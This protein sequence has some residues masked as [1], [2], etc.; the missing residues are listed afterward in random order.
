MASYKKFSKT[1]EFMTPFSAWETIT[2]FI[3]KDKLIWEPFYGDGT[4]AQH[5]RDLGC[6]VYSEQED[7]FSSVHGDIVVS[8]PPFSKK[9]QVFERLLELNN[10]FILLCPA[11]VLHTQWLKRMFPDIQLIIPR[12]RIQFL[13]EGVQLGRCNFECI[14]YC[15]R[16]NLERDVVFL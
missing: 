4:S 13:Y 14:Y 8:N 9:R 1:D 16:M 2:S 6:W 12:K 15:W 5:L 10:P 11:G 7:F 3:P